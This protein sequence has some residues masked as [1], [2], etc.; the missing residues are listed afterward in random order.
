[1]IRTAGSGLAD[2]VP[3]RVVSF[4]QICFSCKLAA[5]DFG[6]VRRICD[7][8]AVGHTY[9]VARRVREHQA[10]QFIPKEGV[11]AATRNRY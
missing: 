5:P 1:V 11:E 4:R 10:E 7:I 8:V 6:R 2:C 9:F 3:P